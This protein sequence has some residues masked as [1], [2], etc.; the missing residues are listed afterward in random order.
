MNVLDDSEANPSVKNAAFEGGWSRHVKRS[1]SIVWVISLP[2]LFVI[3]GAIQYVG[4]LSPTKCNV[5]VLFI[6]CFLLRYREFWRTARYEVPILLLAAYFLVSGL[7]SDTSPLATSVYLYYSACLLLAAPAGRMFA[8]ALVTHNRARI[9]RR[10]ILGCLALELPITALQHQYATVFAAHSAIR[11]GVIDAVFGTFPLNSDA[12]LAGCSIMAVLIYSY[13]STNLRNVLLAACLAFAVIFLGHSKAIQGT[14]VLLLL[15]ILGVNIYRR[16]AIKKYRRILMLLGWL[17]LVVVLALAARTMYGD[18]VQ[19]RSMAAAN[20]ADRSDWI[21]AARLAP[22]GQ[23]F[24]SGLV[25]LLFGHGALTYYNPITKEWL[26]NAGFSTVY[27]LSLDFGLIGLLGYLVYQTRVIFMI[28]PYRTF[29][30]FLCAVWLAFIAFNDALPN[31][32]FIFALNFTVSF[33][34]H[35]FK[36]KHQG[37]N[38]NKLIWSGRA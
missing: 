14:Y 23:L 19:F 11:V 1:L 10:V 5:V 25:H 36:I 35:H 12:V 4:L 18:W 21:T 24:K 13:T 30:F 31:V 16:T 3:G 37:T 27:S 7:A 8:K 6:F 38:E 17:A 20:Y 26:Y 22:F 28:S 29:A 34:M 15:P 9:A 32:A 2:L 33:V